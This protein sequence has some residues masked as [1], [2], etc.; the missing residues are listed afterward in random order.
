[1]INYKSQGSVTVRLMCGGGAIKLSLH[2]VFVAK[3]GGD[4]ILNLMYT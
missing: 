2:F 1:V 4:K 3:V